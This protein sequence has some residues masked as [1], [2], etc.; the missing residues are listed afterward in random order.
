M[1]I[2]RAIIF[3]LL[4]SAFYGFAEAQDTLQRKERVVRVGLCL[5]PALSNIIT[6]DDLQNRTYEWRFRFHGSV[7]QDIHLKKRYY[8]HTE[9]NYSAMGTMYPVDLLDSAGNQIGRGSYKY[10]L[11]YIQVPV[12]AKV[13]F[14]RTLKGYIAAGPYFG[15]L[16]AAKGGVDSGTG[17]TQYPQVN[18]LDDYTTFDLGVK[19]H[20]GIEIPILNEQ[21]LMI[22]ARYTQGFWDISDAEE[23]DWNTSFT[24]MFGYMFEL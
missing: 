16:V 14:G 8:L 4:C 5:G 12:L 20:A 3:L 13:K 9:I 18:L 7:F 1:M 2:R 24:I 22:E 17:S 15:F 6:N 23:R 19:L 10:N 21:R 11:H